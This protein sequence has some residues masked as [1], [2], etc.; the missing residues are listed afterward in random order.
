MYDPFATYPPPGTM[1]ATS[2]PQHAQV[3]PNPI[4][5]SPNNALATLYQKHMKNMMP[6]GQFP[7]NPGTGGPIQGQQAPGDWRDQFQQA[8]MDWRGNRPEQQTQMADWRQQRPMPRD[9]RM[10]TVPPTGF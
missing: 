1:A 3:M 9:Y 2:A 6:N 5:V 7:L 4:P 8:R 10:G